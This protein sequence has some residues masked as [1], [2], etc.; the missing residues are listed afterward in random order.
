MRGEARIALG[1]RTPSR[2]ALGYLAVLSL[3]VGLWAQF[4]PRSFFTE[5]PGLGGEGWVRL[6]GGPYNEHLVRDHGGNNLT[7]FVV[8]IAAAITLD[9]GITA[10]ASAGW[11]VYSVPHFEFHLAHLGGFNR[12]AAV[13]Q[14]AGLGLAIGIPAALLAIVCA[15]P[16]ANPRRYRDRSPTGDDA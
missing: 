8:T 9:R 6:T 16:R 10:H 13:N 12:F 14:M 4:W 11:L 7:L 2:V 5:F 1:W 15:T 3:V